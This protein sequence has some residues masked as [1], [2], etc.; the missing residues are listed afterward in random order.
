MLIALWQRF[1]QQ[2][3]V[4]CEV[5]LP[6]LLIIVLVLLIRWTGLLQ[7]QE[8]M[9][10]DSLSSR[11]SSSTAEHFIVI[12]GIDEADLDR[13]GGFP[14][15][16]QTLVDL[17]KTLQRYSPAVIGLGLFRDMPVQPGHDALAQMLAQNLN[18][19]GVEMAL[20]P[21]PSLN[22]KPPS[23]LPSERI[24]FV[25][26]SVDEDGKLRRMVL[27]SQTER[28]MLYSFA[29]QLAQRY[30]ASQNIPFQAENFT[31]KSIQLGTSELSQF[32]ASSGGYIRAKTMGHQ[33]L[34]NFCAAQSLFQTLSL[35]D[36]LQQ[37]FAP[38]WIRD[39]IVIIGM[40]APSVKDVFFTSALRE[41]LSSRLISRLI[42]ATQLIYGVEVQAHAANQI[43]NIALTRQ[44]QLRVWADAWEYLWIASWGL[45]GIMLEILLQSPW[46]S[47]LSL[48]VATAILIG[49]SFFALILG[50]WIPL[51][52]AGLALNGAGLVTA[53]LE[54]NLRFELEYRRVAVERMYEAIHNGPLQ[55]LAVVLRSLDESN[56][57]GELQQQLQSLNEELRSIFQHMRQEMLTRSDRLYLKG[58]LILDLQAPISELLYQVYN[59]TLEIQAPGFVDIQTY[60]SPD[61]EV[62]K[63]NHFSVKQKRGLCLFLQ[64]ALWNVGK[65]AIGTTRLDVMCLRDGNNYVLRVTDNGLGSASVHEGQGTK[66]AKVIARELGGRFQRRSHYP[67]GTICELIFPM[68][69]NWLK[70]WVRVQ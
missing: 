20:N 4:W 41:T 33:A 48:V 27:A 1:R 29:L 55:H 19:V 53:F 66:Q 65:H 49:I 46:R 25:D 62:L 64:E 63:R 16:D 23:M 3:I 35:T 70:G 30:L 59:Y 36:V 67:K 37:N 24:G 5:A 15:P 44:P 43:I 61:F 17:L 13:V 2:A 56:S 50:W 60:I 34:F 32:Q 22:I 69:R 31:S 26:V 42:P 38:E 12:V 21:E 40:T 51:V 9:A 11:C 68:Q 47:V 6:G 28:G 8:W 39:R 10:F 52:P 57:P 7:I 54:R 45:L 14:I 58:N 18:L